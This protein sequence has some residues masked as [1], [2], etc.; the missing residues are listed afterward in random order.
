MTANGRHLKLSGRR[1][2]PPEWV[3]MARSALGGRIELDPMSE[4]GF[5]QIVQ[6]ERIYTADDNCFTKSWACE[7]MLI[8]PHGGLVV[9]AWVRLTSSFMEGYVKSAIWIGFSVE[10][11]NILA[12]FSPHP[13]DFSK[14]TV[15]RRIDFLDENLKPLGR[16]THANYV[17]GLG[18]DRDRFER[19]FS[20]RGR[21]SHG[22]YAV[23]EME[24]LGGLVS[25][26]G[27][28]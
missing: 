3:E 24:V 13:D 9:D 16:P 11:L 25:F 19:S 28:P 21:F 1:G 6:A 4:P 27:H 8:N 15:R 14:L 20:C 10:Q 12:D 17:V 18:I 2:T 22:R 7:T 26:G 23:Q 5:N